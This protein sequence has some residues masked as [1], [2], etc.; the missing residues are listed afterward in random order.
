VLRKVLR[1][2]EQAERA[3]DRARMTADR[4][5]LDAASGKVPP[6]RIVAAVDRNPEVAQFLARRLASD[7]SNDHL[8]A[9]A[10]SSAWAL[11]EGPERHTCVAIATAFGAIMHRRH[12]DVEA[13]RTALRAAEFHVERA[14]SHLASAAVAEARA[15]FYRQVHQLDTA[16]G[17]AVRAI[18]FYSH[19]GRQQDRGR[20]ELLKCTILIDKD[21]VSEAMR[22][23]AHALARFDRRNPRLLLSLV[24]NFA[25]ILAKCDALDYVDGFIADN[26]A[27]FEA[28]TLPEL[29]RVQ[30]AFAALFVEHRRLPEAERWYRASRSSF[31]AAGAAVPLAAC[32]ID[33]VEKALLPQ[34]KRVEIADLAQDCVTVLARAGMNEHALRAWRLLQRSATLDVARLALILRSRRLRRPI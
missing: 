28:A 11:P 30:W 15:D 34:G 26:A 18:A 16:W 31:A 10:T 4:L 1:A 9:V 7:P 25:L 32:S 5:V 29:A 21:D 2:I 33:F 12:G 20:V 3:G 14:H 27:V 8:L 23:A 22:A 24:G 13:A 17:A 6:A 19:L